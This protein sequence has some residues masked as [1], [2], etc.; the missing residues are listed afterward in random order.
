MATATFLTSGDIAK[1]L[2]EDAMM[3]RHIITSRGIA[4]C[5]M[6]GNVRIFP[7]SAVG[8]VKD[9]LASITRRRRRGAPV[10]A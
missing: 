7:E 2:G 5:G 9:A 10:T 1:T 3:V 4:P 6:A 8:E